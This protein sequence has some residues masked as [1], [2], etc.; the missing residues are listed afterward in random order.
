MG[1][2]SQG[3]HALR[4]VRDTTQ[5]I[6]LSVII[7]VLEVVAYIL[8][9]KAFALSLDPLAMTLVMAVL[10]LGLSAPSAPGFVGVFEALITSALALYGIQGDEALAFAATL[11]LVHFVPGTLLGLAAAWKSGLTL[12][13][14]SEAEAQHR[15]ESSSHLST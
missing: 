10:A 9:A 14:V 4:S 6:L 8:V 5:V 11:H 1:K 13:D 15:M 3:L 7:W 2:L 12:S